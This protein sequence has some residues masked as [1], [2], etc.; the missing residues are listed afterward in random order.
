M[1]RKSERIRDLED[2]VESLKKTIDIM[3]CTIDRL[4]SELYAAKN[5]VMI[6]TSDKYIESINR[7]QIDPVTG[8]LKAVS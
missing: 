8:G 5:P 3:K 2:Q 1:K 4:D 7:N 6:H